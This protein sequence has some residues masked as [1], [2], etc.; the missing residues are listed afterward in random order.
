MSQ[1]HPTLRQPPHCTVTKNALASYP[2]QAR[3]H[4]GRETL[5]LGNSREKRCELR[6]LVD[7]QR[8]AEGVLMLTRNLADRFQSV[9][10]IIG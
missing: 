5:L 9:S 8:R 3:M 6:A 2:T 7:I 4:T 1:L 10:T